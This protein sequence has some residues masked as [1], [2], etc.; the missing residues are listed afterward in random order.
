MDLTAPVRP[1][2]P[3]M[4]LDGDLGDEEYRR[5]DVDGHPDLDSPAAG[6]GSRSDHGLR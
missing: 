6:E 2:D 3:V 1:G 4:E 5:E